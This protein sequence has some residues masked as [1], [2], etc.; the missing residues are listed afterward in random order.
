MAFDIRVP[1]ATR[2]R[3]ESC[4]PERKQQQ[5]SIVRRD[6]FDA[7]DITPALVIRHGMEAAEVEQKLERTHN[8][9]LFDT[10]DV[11]MHE[12]DTNSR[13]G[14]ASARHVQSA[15]DRVYASGL[16]AVLSEIDRE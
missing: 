10:P 15:L 7:F 3:P 5:V 14:G 13:F 4:W 11:P 1:R 2:P 9:R 6:T 16:P 8:P 12:R